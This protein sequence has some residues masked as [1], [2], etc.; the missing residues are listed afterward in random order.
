MEFMALRSTLKTGL[1]KKSII[2]PEGAHQPA[3][4]FLQYPADR[5][6]QSKNNKSNG[7]TA[8]EI[9][10]GFILATVFGTAS[11]KT[12]NRGV[13][14]AMAVH[15]PLSPKILIKISAVSDEIIMLTD[16]LHAI[17][18]INRRRG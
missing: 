17:I 13:R 6:Q 9:A 4:D 10:I 12:R 14:T 8:L 5:E 18:V 11:Q 3:G 2:R 1:A 15:F 16:S 7:D